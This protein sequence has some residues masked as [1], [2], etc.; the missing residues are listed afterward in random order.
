MLTVFFRRSPKF[1]HE[2]IEEDEA[3]ILHAI[4]F[5]ELVTYIESFRHDPETA[6]VF[7]MPN[8]CRLYRIHLKDLGSKF[9]ARFKVHAEARKKRIR[10]YIDCFG[11][12]TSYKLVLTI[13]SQIANSVIQKFKRGGV[14]V[15][16]SMMRKLFTVGI[17]D[18]NTNSITASDS[19][20]GTDIFLIQRRE[21]ERDGQEQLYIACQVRNGNLKNF[22]KDKINLS[23]RGFQVRQ[24][25]KPCLDPDLQICHRALPDSNSSSSPPMIVNVADT[26]DQLE[27]PGQGSGG[28]ESIQLGVSERGQEIVDTC[29]DNSSSS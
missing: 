11:D 5:V 2:E 21:V 19:V 15:P 1:A 23:L 22:L 3:S 17:V 6:P 24:Q 9:L 8:L 29:L 10:R 4:A 16:T 25:R 7:S 13:S 12:E 20:R 27:V 28:S 14:G 26:Q 18:H